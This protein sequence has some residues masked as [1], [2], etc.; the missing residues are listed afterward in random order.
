MPEK[1]KDDKCKCRGGCELIVDQLT[2]IA[3]AQERAYPPPP[4]PEPTPV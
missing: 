4:P 1:A 2:R 3:D